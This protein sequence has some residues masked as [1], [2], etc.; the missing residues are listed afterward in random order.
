MVAVGAG[1]R[2]IQP[3]RT[4]SRRAVPGT[5]RSMAPRSIW[6][7]TIMLGTIAVPV[8]VHSATESRTVHFHEVHEPDGARIEHRRV[9]AKTGREVPSDK[10]VRGYELSS[11][12]YV[13]LDKEEID[14]AAGERGRLLDVEELV[15]AGAIDPVFFDKTYYLGSRE[16]GDAYRLLHAALRRTG[17]AGLAR[18]VFHN[19][20]Y[21]VAIRSLDGVLA[22]H[23][24]RFQDELVDPGEDDVGAPER[25]PT[26]REIDMASTLVETLH[27]D[28]DPKLLTDEYRDTV[29]AYLDAKRHGNA[30]EPEPYEPPEPSGDLLAALQASLEGS[31]R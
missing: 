27:T 30:P 28:F 14:A 6:N 5:R 26:D 1:V 10:I 18:W 20:E 15:D 23:T 8:R 22:M 9:A 12:E 2:N 11:G 13:V 25:K 21:L 31:R 24:M 19:R 17:R 4:V 7:G 16:A 3:S 29:L